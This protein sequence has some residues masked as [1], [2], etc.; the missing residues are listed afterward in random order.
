M[1]GCPDGV[2]VLARGAHLS[3]D[4][5]ACLMEYTALLAGEPFSDHPA[6]T[7]PVLASLAR[8][9]NDGVSDRARAGL[10]RRAPTLAALGPDRAGVAAAVAVAAARPNRGGSGS[11]TERWRTRTTA[12]LIRRDQ[13]GRGRWGRGRDQAA[14]ARCVDAALAQIAFPVTARGTR[15]RALIGLL[16]RALALATHA[17][18][19]DAPGGE[20]ATPHCRA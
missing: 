8:R 7:H 14:A 9:V 19:L 6:C 15:D 18:V 1:A 3:P 5:G 4:D 13:P 12:A 11:W 17:P 2:P 10:A 20:T 16:D